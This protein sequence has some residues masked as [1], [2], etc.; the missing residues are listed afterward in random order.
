[1]LDLGGLCASEAILRIRTFLLSKR[2]VSTPFSSMYTLCLNSAVGGGGEGAV[3]SILAIVPSEWRGNRKCFLHC[4]QG[5]GEVIFREQ[6][7]IP[8]DE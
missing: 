2:V 4:S 6:P 1:M 8:R 5:H 7:I 3:V